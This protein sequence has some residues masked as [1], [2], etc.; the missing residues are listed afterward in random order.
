MQLKVVTL[1]LS[2]L[3][4]TAGATDAADKTHQQMMAEI[5]MLQEQ[6]QQMAA[7]LG[8]LADTLKTVTA[9][10]DDQ[11]NASRKAF[12][13]QKLLVD[14]I[15]EGVR[16][17]REKADDANVRLSSMSQELEAQRQIISSLPTSP[18]PSTGVPPPTGDP[19]TAPHRRPRSRR[20]RTS[21]RRRHTTRHST[22]TLAASTISRSKASTST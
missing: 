11:T 10:M 2:S 13:D 8:G 18:Q 17:L 20:R 4:V 15:A 12:A 9:R 1:M 19:S 5:R 21:L 3:L 14:G 22:T 16:I 7:M 6:Q